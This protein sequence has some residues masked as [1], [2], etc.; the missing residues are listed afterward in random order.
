MNISFGIIF[1]CLLIGAIIGFEAGKYIT[2]KKI[3]ELLKEFAD[4][5]KKE[6]EESKK[7]REEELNNF[8]P[9]A[10]K[11]TIDILKTL[12]QQKQGDTDG[13]CIDISTEDDLK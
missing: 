4:N 8:N 1:V 6:A 10:W 13:D 11:A 12:S 9:A 2:G 7:R 3:S 5:M